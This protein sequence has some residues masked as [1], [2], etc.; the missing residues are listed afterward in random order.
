MQQQIGSIIVGKHT[1]TSQMVWA[2]I[3]RKLTFNRMFI[4]IWL[5]TEHVFGEWWRSYWFA[6]IESINDMMMLSAAAAA[7]A[8]IDW[9]ELLFIFGAFFFSL[10]RSLSFDY[11][12]SNDCINQSYALSFAAI[13]IDFTFTLKQLKKRSTW[14]MQSH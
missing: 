11:F 2:N 5:K 13:L 14:I 8:V 3:F 1:E 12:S 9:S 6:A 10:I 7:A 4:Q